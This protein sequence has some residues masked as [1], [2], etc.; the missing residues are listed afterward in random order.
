MAPNRVIVVKHPIRPSVRLAY[1][2]WLSLI[3]ARTLVAQSGN[4]IQEPEFPHGSIV[5][6]VVCRNDPQ[7]SYALYLPS[8]FSMA[9]KW[10]VI[11]AF[12]PGARGQ[13]AA[14]VI[15]KAAEKFGYIVAASDN[16]RNGAMGGSS[17]AAKAMWEDVQQRFP[18]D[19]RRRYFAGMSGGA[20]AA[21]AFALAC[22]CVEGVI[23]NAAGFPV[24]TPEPGNLKFVFFGAVGDADFNY[25][26]FAQL[27]TNLE[28]TGARH[29][30]RIFEGPYGWAPSEV[31]IQAL[32]WLDIQSMIA[33]A[34]PLDWNRVQ[35]SLK[36]ATAHAKTYEAKGDLLNAVREYQSL[37][38]DF[39][40]LADVTAAKTR[41]SDLEKS[42]ELKSTEKQDRSRDRDVSRP[43]PQTR[44]GA[45]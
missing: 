34:M 41:V 20:R 31:W 9:R 7:Q 36:E 4:N 18:I 40:N 8:N 10:P 33:G 23:A 15:Q 13:V 38:R 44:T 2:L 37:V 12:D 22:N 19:E 28:K 32:D 35:S 1:V 17:Q 24:S 30:I 6:R 21:T 45:H 27:R 11:Y 14:E 5:P 43:P 3:S 39:A 29:R 26:E 42:K 16:S 25:G